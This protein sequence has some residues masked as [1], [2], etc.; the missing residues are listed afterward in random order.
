[1]FDREE[2]GVPFCVE[3]GEYVEEPYGLEERA[4]EA[5]ALAK[6]RP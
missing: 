1:V 4:D 5:Y 2:G 3:C 6:E